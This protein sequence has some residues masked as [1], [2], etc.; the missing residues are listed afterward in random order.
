MEGN[1][2]SYKIKSHHEAVM[3]QMFTT[4]IMAFSML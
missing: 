1:E 2:E 3:A 4:V